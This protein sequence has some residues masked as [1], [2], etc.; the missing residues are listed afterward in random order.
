M[1]KEEEPGSS[2]FEQLDDDDQMSLVQEFLVFLVEYRNWWLLPILAVL[3]LLGLFV[4]LGG[5][6]AAPF[7]YTLF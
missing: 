7:I 2:K 5:T 6:G 1:N 4:V 3:A